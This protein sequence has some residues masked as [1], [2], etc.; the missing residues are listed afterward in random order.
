MKVVNLL[1]M[2]FLY[3]QSN[4]W[5]RKE[6]PNSNE[7]MIRMPSGFTYKTENFIELLKSRKEHGQELSP[8]RIVYVDNLIPYIQVGSYDYDVENDRYFDFFAKKWCCRDY[9]SNAEIYLNILSSL[10]Q[11]ETQWLCKRIVHLEKSVAYLSS[12]FDQIREKNSVLQEFIQTCESVIDRE[13]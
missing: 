8:K 4:Q 2:E 7:F 9:L 13:K 11:L 12:I 10:Q 3:I 1:Q 5:E 6:I